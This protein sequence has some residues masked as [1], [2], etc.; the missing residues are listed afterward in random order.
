MSGDAPRWRIGELGRR[1]GLSADTLRAWERRY[2]L[3]SPQRSSGGYRL[4]S[5]SDEARL[6]RMTELVG[7]GLS[8]AEAARVVLAESAGGDGEGHE[9]GLAGR[10][11]GAFAELDVSRAEAV[12]D[13]MLIELTLDA[14]IGEVVLPCLRTLGEDWEA[15]RASVGEEHLASAVVQSRLLALARDWD[16]GVGPLV[17]L[18]CM[19][20]E[21]HAL[22]LICFGLALRARGM[23]VAYLGADTPLAEAERVAGRRGAAA[24]VLSAVAPERFAEH[25]AELRA[26]A[27][28]RRVL[29]GG[30]GARGVPG[31]LPDDV[32]DAADAL[33]GAE[34]AVAQA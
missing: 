31:A 27:S 28:R 23:R 6:R 1:V 26:L 17:V 8:P 2:G 5:P 15:G 16:R 12:F 7:G 13:R 34:A 20:G 25:R 3:L 30:A 4:Y 33:A 22:G 21:Q 29:L 24:I 19:P 32:M 11:R 9:D 10:L 14:A 18:G